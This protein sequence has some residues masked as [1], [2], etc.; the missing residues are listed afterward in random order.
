ME[1]I[2]DSKKAFLW[3]HS[4]RIYLFA[5]CVRLIDHKGGNDKVRERWLTI[6][7]ELAKALAWW[8]EARP[9]QVRTFMFV[10]LGYTRIMGRFWTH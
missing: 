3:Q 2:L 1:S 9:C 7:T 4:D 5:G 8:Q 6:H 10:A